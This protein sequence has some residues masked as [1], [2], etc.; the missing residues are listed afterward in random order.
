M[1]IL[2]PASEVAGAGGVSGNLTSSGGGFSSGQPELCVDNTPNGG[3]NGNI[4]QN[5]YIASGAG[6]SYFQRYYSEIPEDG[7]PFGIGGYGKIGGGGFNGATSEE[8]KS[9]GGYIIDDAAYG[10][11][12]GTVTIS[13]ANVYAYNGSYITDGSVDLS[14][15]DNKK[16]YQ[17]IIYAQV[18]YDIKAIRENE[19]INKVTSRTAKDLINEFSGLNKYRTIDYSTYQKYGAMGIGSGAGATET[20]NGTL[21]INK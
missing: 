6:G 1:D 5:G 13:N 20:S 14:N 4:P 12:G 7:N 17:S 8:R 19:D 18:G 15:L 11:E 3:T 10:G 9:N 2:Q 21:T 16:N